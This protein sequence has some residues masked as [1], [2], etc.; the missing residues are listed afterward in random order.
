MKYNAVSFSK[1]NKVVVGA[2]E[3]YL[4]NGKWKELYLPQRYDLYNE[5]EHMLRGSNFY[6]GIALPSKDAPD[7]AF[8]GLIVFD[9][10]TRGEDTWEVWQP[11]ME[12]M[13][14]YGMIGDNPTNV[15]MKGDSFH[16]WVNIGAD[17]QREIVRSNRLKTSAKLYVS[18]SSSI[19][20]IFGG[21][22][23]RSCKEGFATDGY[24]PAVSGATEIDFDNV[25]TITKEILDVFT[26]DEEDIFTK[27]SF[28]KSY[29]DSTDIV[30]NVP[31]VHIGCTIKELI[32]ELID[33]K[34]I[35]SL[36]SYSAHVS[37][38]PMLYTIEQFY[39]VNPMDDY[40]EIFEDLG[41]TKINDHGIDRS[42]VN[43]SNTA[44]LSIGMTN[45][46]RDAII[47][48]SMD[49]EDINF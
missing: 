20:L 25:P 18:K 14:E 3:C 41:N 44:E 7:D 45:R 27:V 36:D 47:K 15:E 2:R 37:N 48:L 43:F 22:C 8:N 6:Y 1:I 10:D 5:K 21:K 16:V 11:T 13:K 26:L 39:G 12:V 31:N 38:V 29:R 19:D 23:V 40:R 33:V 30:S 4:P 35:D 42:Y 24:K 32:H 9:L 34:Y 17:L 28:E 49:E 46:I